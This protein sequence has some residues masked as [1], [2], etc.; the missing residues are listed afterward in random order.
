MPCST[1]SFAR[2]PQKGSIVSRE[3]SFQ[4]LDP[5]GAGVHQQAPDTGRLIKRCAVRCA[6]AVC[7]R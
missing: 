3:T 5:P 2:G 6:I 1:Y 4:A 7:R